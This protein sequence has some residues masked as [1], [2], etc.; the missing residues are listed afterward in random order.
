[1]KKEKKKKRRD[2]TPRGSQTGRQGRGLMRN[3]LLQAQSSHVNLITTF[4]GAAFPLELGW[5]FFFQLAE[6]PRPFNS[7][8]PLETARVRNN[9]GSPAEERMG[10]KPMC[11]LPFSFLAL[12]L[13]AAASLRALGAS[14][15]PPGPVGSPAPCPEML[16]RACRSQR[17]VRARPPLA[18]RGCLPARPARLPPRRPG[19]FFPA[20]AGFRGARRGLGVQR[21]GLQSRARSQVVS[22]LGVGAENRILPAR[23]ACACGCGPGA[24]RAAPPGPPASLP[25]GQRAALQP[26]APRWGP[27]CGGTRA[28][29]GLRPVW[30]ARGALA[31]RCPFGGR[32]L[33]G[34]L[35][36]GW[37][38]LGLGAIP[39]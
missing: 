24:G 38:R 26:P 14:A 12:D 13:R 7:P 22:G 1:M 20:R 32:C 23:R 30:R 34:A 18:R 25:W 16:P 3:T 6:L 36:Q 35:G 5:V 2:G 19:V 21:E 17:W 37:R 8:P 9:L 31:G 39:R 11:P 10:F 4:L 27:C 29:V 33:P 15:E 28:S